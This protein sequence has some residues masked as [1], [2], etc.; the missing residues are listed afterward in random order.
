MYKKVTVGYLRNAMEGLRKATRNLGQG[1]RFLDEAGTG[2]LPVTNRNA[3]HY[4]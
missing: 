4:T 3:S 1:S 2:R